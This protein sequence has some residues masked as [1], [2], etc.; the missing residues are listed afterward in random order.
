MLIGL[1]ADSHDRVPAIRELLE[2]I[3][4]RGAQMV[5]HAGDYCS[6]FSLVPF[7]DQNIPVA[8]VFG[9]NDGDREGLRAIA[10]KGMGIDLYESPHSI[11][12]GGRRILLVHDLG[13]V[14]ER[15]LES[16]EIIVH[17]FTHRQ[18][19][20]ETDGGALLVNPGEACGW[21]HGAPSAAILDLDTKSVE[22]I[23]LTEPAWKV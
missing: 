1:M 9:R 17:G 11:E 16:H 12:L 6:P 21:L 4:E 15:S 2:R 5:L 10:T 20:R 3:T 19:T 22:L 7:V 18:E 23:S 14:A 8:G 13:E